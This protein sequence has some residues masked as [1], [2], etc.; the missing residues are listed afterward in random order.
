M[1]KFTLILSLL[2]AM[3]TTAM[4]QTVSYRPGARTTTLEAGKQ[5][6]ISV[7]TWWGSACTK[8]LYNNEGTL[9]VSELMPSTILGNENY[10]FTVEEVG[11][12]KLVYVKNSDG[13]Y[14]Q[15][16]NL[17]STETKTGIYVIP[18]Y[19]AK[20]VC[21][22]SDVDA[23][24][25]NGNKIAYASI[26]AETPIVSVQKNADYTVSD[27]R[28]GWRHIGGLS[29][30][31]D[32]CTAFAFYEVEPI[33]PEL[34]TDAS[35]PKYYAIKNI[36]TNEYAHYSGDASSMTLQP[37]LGNSGKFYFTGS[38]NEDG[39]LTVKIHNA[40]TENLCAACDQWNADGIDWYVV[41]SGAGTGL[42]ISNNAAIT[43]N[44]TSWNDAGGYGKNI[45]YWNGNDDGSTWKFLE[46]DTELDTRADISMSTT[47][48]P[49][50]YTIRNARQ[51]GKY[52][53]FTAEE[54]ALSQSVT[55]T[56]PSYWYFVEDAT[57]EVSDGWV[58]CKIYNVAK[59][60]SI[61]DPAKSTFDDCTYYI[62]KSEHSGM[63]G[64]FISKST[65][66][67]ETAWN[68]YGGASVCEYYYNDAG[69]VWWIEKADKTAEELINEAKT[70]KAGFLKKIAHY[71][72]ADYYNYSAADIASAKDAI[73][74]A[75]TDNL[76]DAVYNAF[77]SSPSVIAALEN[78]TVAATAPAAG[79]VIQLLNKQYNTYLNGDD[80]NLSGV[81]DNEGL[82]TYWVVESG[83]EE[84]YVKLKNASS[85]KYIGSIT[86]SENV[87]MQAE[88]GSHN[89]IFS[90]QTTSY[91]VFKY[92]ASNDYGYGHIAGHNV[93]VGWERSAD[94]TQWAINQTTLEEAKAALSSLV[95]EYENLIGDGL[96]QYSTTPEEFTTA[97]NTAK[98]ALSAAESSVLDLI[99]AKITLKNTVSTLETVATGLN[100]PED[101]CYLRI[102]AV[103]GW[104]DDARYLSSV[105]SGV[106]TGRA[107]FV[108][109]A[110]ET[111]VFY[112][113]DGKLLAVNNGNYLGDASNFA[114]YLENNGA[115]AIEFL[116]ATNNL[117]SAYNIKFKNARSLYVN[118]GN[119][120][121]AAGSP[122]TSDVNGY[123][124]NLVELTSDEITALP[125][126]TVTVG[127]AR[128]S[129]LYLDYAV[130]IPVGITAY[131]VT[132][133]EEGYA[134]LTAVSGAIPANTGV[135]LEGDADSYVFTSPT[136]G[137]T[138]TDKG[139]LKGTVEDTEFNESGKDYYV[140]SN[141]ANGIAFYKD[142]KSNGVFLNNAN[143]AYLV[144]DS[145]SGK[146]ASFSFRIEGTTAIDEVE[147]AEAGEQV[148]YDLTGRRVESI[149]APG[150]YIVNGNK[151]VI[152]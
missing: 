121:D 147:A 102:M 90:N 1:R 127:D 140:L 15:A 139:V 89:I 63:V 25:E 66:D 75:S 18:Y 4:A 30:G 78:N 110:D 12:G 115:T 52:A 13:K 123:C 41:P 34:T 3:V 58:A 120:T 72:F 118:P 10:L 128:Y 94:A 85:N 62:K 103:E 107:A 141:G 37:Y 53:T 111:T 9:T 20:A 129:T 80:E 6:F 119:Y 116:P 152:K 130:E 67:N 105:N 28:N 54:S 134:D 49:V 87:T 38:K 43:D 19:D 45:G 76:F 64:F 40:A 137:W 71:E 100:M 135:V 145:E 69:S 109:D 42:A 79:D 84:G 60:K 65:T 33:Y 29:A 68:D 26:T 74:S 83:D 131:T 50:L 124:F 106:N 93:L 97:L 55:P 44:G 70:L 77:F 114:A 2:A 11:D 143:K 82:A 148:I 146:S 21:C 14:L 144:M 125:K 61:A 142:G 47:D 150:I 113:K 57:V 8:L 122:V 91:A 22:G 32:W 149:S 86:M 98:S 73:E 24:D 59:E 96:G 88:A 48:A 35:N 132:I 108:A 17:A 133:D 51:N 99:N 117:L 81:T 92:A 112:Y 16:D 7:A 5:Y 56:S 31:V 23:C 95:A 36:R 104:N 151:V 46:Y 138:I 101:G 126:H 39:S 136:T 27:N